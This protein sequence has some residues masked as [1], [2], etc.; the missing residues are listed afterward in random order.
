MLSCNDDEEAYPNIITELVDVMS[1]A[2]GQLTSFTTDRGLTYRITNDLT[3][4]KKNVVYRALCGY[5][6]QGEEA[7]LYELKNAWCLKDST[8]NL[9]HDPTDVLSV[10]SSGRYLNMHL[11]PLT[12]GGTQYWGFATDSLVAGHL[13]LSLHHNQNGD[14]TSYSTY[15]YASIPFDDWDNLQ[16]GD[17]VTL[18]IHT[19]K[20]I[21]TFGFTYRGVSSSQN[22]SKA[23]SY[24]EG[25]NL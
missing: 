14:A 19:F 15:V 2:S 6:P 1:D 20:G 23:T 16:A 8:K 11:S 7:T 9:R 4:Y 12:H 3:G 13:Y 25:R 10:W 5:V 21:S 18:A 17:S 22:Q 24:T